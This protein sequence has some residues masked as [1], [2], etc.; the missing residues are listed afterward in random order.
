M[1]H[2]FS[3]LRGVENEGSPCAET[4]TGILVLEDRRSRDNTGGRKEE[5]DGRRED[6]RSARG[7]SRPARD[8]SRSGRDVNSLK[9]VFSQEERTLFVVGLSEEVQDYDVKGVLW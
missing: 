7:D 5:P 9:P 1:K 8:E 6:S 3:F 2:F 4:G